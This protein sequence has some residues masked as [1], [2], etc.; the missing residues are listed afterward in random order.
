MQ[1]TDNYDKKKGW[2]DYDIFLK[3]IKRD[4]FYCVLCI[5]ISFCIR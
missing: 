1:K 2:T 3:N 4:Y 5:N